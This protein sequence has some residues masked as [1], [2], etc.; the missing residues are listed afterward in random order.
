MTSLLRIYGRRAGLF[1]TDETLK[2][3]LFMQSVV[4]L[5]NAPL[6]NIGVRFFSYAGKILAAHSSE[7][8]AVE[9]IPSSG[10]RTALCYTTI[11]NEFVEKQVRC[12]NSMV[13]SHHFLSVF[14]FSGYSSH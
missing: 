3:R 2:V 10:S 12:P 6:M 8:V 14:S 4:P 13:L 11:R 1:H 5:G 7:I 9:F